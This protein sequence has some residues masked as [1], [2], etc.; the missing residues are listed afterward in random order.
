VLQAKPLLN[1]RHAAVASDVDV[2]VD[3][4]VDEMEQRLLQLLQEGTQV[5]PA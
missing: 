4:D 2:D 1:S 3:V 5:R